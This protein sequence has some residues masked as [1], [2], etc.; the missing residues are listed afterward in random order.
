MCTIFISDISFDK[1]F[2]FKTNKDHLKTALSVF[3][4]VIYIYS[5]KW[6]VKKQAGV[7][8]CQAQEKLRL[9]KKALPSTKVS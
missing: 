7:E 6:I 8:L 1:L 3:I 2:Y 5:F 9:A 4:A